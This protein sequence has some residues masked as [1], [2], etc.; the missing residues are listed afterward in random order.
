LLGWNIDACSFN[1]KSCFLH[2]A[3]VYHYSA[4]NNPQFPSNAFW[5]IK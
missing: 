2:H 5:A 3:L 4:C 1:A